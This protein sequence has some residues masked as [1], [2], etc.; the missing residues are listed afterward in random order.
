MLLFATSIFAGTKWQELSNGIFY[1][2]ILLT[3]IREKNAL[4]KIIHIFKI[5]PQVYKLDIV[6]ARNIGSSAF[7]V[8]MMA[9]KSASILAINGGYFTPEYKALG[10]LVSRGKEINK[11][12]MVGWWHIFQMKNSKPEVLLKQDFKLSPDVEMAIEAGPRLL[13]DGKI[14]GGLKEGLAERTAIGATED[15]KIIIAITDAAPMTMNAFASHIKAAGGLNVLNLD[16]G[17]S[18]QLYSKINN[19]ELHRP[20]FGPVPNSV[21]VQTR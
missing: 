11:L 15:G 5:D 20:G 2:K 12:K 19:F 14:A 6:T 9:T 8:K 18:T 1:K 21:V 16:G 7:D 13:I 17:S 4:P 10:L 3:T